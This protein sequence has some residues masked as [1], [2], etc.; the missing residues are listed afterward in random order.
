[1]KIALGFLALI[2]ML[3]G[4]GNMSADNWGPG[5]LFFGLGIGA[6]MLMPDG[7]LRH[8]GSIHFFGK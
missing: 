6:I 5:L 2:F 8:K 7:G 3:I 1:M 4:I